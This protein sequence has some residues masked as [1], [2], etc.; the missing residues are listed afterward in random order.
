MVCIEGSAEAA[1]EGRVWSRPVSAYQGYHSNAS[2]PSGLSNIYVLAILEAENS[3][4][5]TVSHSCGCPSLECRASFPY[6]REVV[7]ADFQLMASELDGNGHHYR[8]MCWLL[9]GALVRKQELGC[10]G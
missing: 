2:Q 5:L 8:H 6:L 7:E 9:Q 1:M 3:N 4:F 10:L